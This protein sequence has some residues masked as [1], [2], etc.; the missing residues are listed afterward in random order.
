MDVSIPY[1]RSQVDLLA[2]I[3]VAVRDPSDTRWTVAEKYAALNQVL[4]TWAD[5]VMLPHRY[6]IPGGWVAGTQDY[7]LPSYM[8]PPFYPE[9]LRHVPYDNYITESL[10]ANWQ[11]VPGWEVVPNGSGGQVIRLY[12]PP[13]TVEGRVGFYAP[14]SRVPTTIPI[15]GGPFNS[16]AT[17]VVVTATGLDIDDV[18]YIKCENEWISYAG[19]TR[20]GANSNLLTNL[21]RGL[22]GTTADT[23][24]GGSNVAWGVA[25][26]DMRLHKLLLDM[27]RSVLHSYYIQDGGVHEKGMHQQAMGYY[28][29]LA[30]NF[31][32]TYRPKRQ[33]QGLILNSKAFALRR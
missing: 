28:D 22:Y 6:T 15:T 27:W 21:V 29:Q 30:M 17:N 19:V 23:H 20:T 16:V 1:L 3:K 14:N 10:T 8:R 13:R 9:L 18:G 7:A 2:E 24:A 11:D 4:M 33:S 5:K 32:P 12:S 31:W 25:I 26:D